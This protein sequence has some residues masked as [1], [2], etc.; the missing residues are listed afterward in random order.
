MTTAFS[1]SINLLGLHLKTEA[2]FA[3][4]EILRHRAPRDL[5]SP[6]HNFR[7]QGQTN[8]V[9]IFLVSCEIALI[10]L[11]SLCIMDFDRA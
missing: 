6:R 7:N 5:V 11:L 1:E 9:R 2:A 10:D 4:V 3:D 8:K